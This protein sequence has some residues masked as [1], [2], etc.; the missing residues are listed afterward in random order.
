M[1]L[2]FVARRTR[3]RLN[4]PRGE[5]GSAAVGEEDDLK[6]GG[7]YFVAAC[8]GML[9]MSKGGLGHAVTGYYVELCCRS[10]MVVNLRTR[11]Q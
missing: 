2:S 10:G 7:R 3:N 9:I 1:A 8:R 5:G 6:V 4:G 11:A